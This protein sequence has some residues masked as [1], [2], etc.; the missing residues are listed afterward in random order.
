[1][2]RNRERAGERRA[3]RICNALEVQQSHCEDE[4][5]ACDKE[6]TRSDVLGMAEIR[7]GVTH[8]T[9]DGGGHDQ[10]PLDA[11]VRESAQPHERQQTCEQRQRRTMKGTGNRDDDSD[12]IPARGAHGQ[13]GSDITHGV[14]V[15]TARKA[16][17][18]LLDGWCRVPHEWFVVPNELS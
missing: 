16:A 14:T 8:Q 5:H 18:R 4:Q 10:A 6:K 12:A 1:M 9:D 2:R 11:F 13:T 3:H 15:S 17:P 7:A